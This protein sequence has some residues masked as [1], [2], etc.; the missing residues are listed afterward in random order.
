[1][2]SL[3]HS[4]TIIKADG[5]IIKNILILLYNNL[6][7]YINLSTDSSEQQIN[8]TRYLTRKLTEK[9]KPQKS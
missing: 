2:L 7:Q 9:V 8:G 4:T 1:M 3:L 6:Q 5:Q